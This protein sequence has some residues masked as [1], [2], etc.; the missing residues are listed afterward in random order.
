M[1]QHLEIY[2]E[3]RLQAKIDRVRRDIEH[4]KQ[5]SE[6]KTLKVWNKVGTKSEH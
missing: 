1:L 6:L 5:I 3:L 4:L 2:I